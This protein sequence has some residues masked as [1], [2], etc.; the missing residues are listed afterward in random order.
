MSKRFGV[1]LPTPNAQNQHQNR[2][3][4]NQ[5][6]PT[7]GASTRPVITAGRLPT[8]IPCRRDPKSTQTCYC[9]RA[10]RPG[11]QPTLVQSCGKNR[12]VVVCPAALATSS[13]A[14]CRDSNQLS[15]YCLMRQA[16]QHPP[17]AYWASRVHFQGGILSMTLLEASARPKHRCIR[18]P[19][20]GLQFGVGNLSLE[21]VSSLRAFVQG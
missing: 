20:P 2:V 11:L 6:K 3:V 15:P 13:V 8:S 7:L 1:D 17:L 16:P 9:L 12:S 21:W 10:A 5:H 18:I 4:R 19:E 14:S